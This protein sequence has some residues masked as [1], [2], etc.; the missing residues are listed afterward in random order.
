[1]RI[2]L[3][4]AGTRRLTARTRRHEECALLACPEN[5]GR[6]T[7]GRALRHGLK[8]I[9]VVLRARSQRHTCRFASRAHLRRR[10]TL[11]G[12]HRR[13][14]KPMARPTVQRLHR[15]L[16]LEPEQQRPSDL[17]TK[18]TSFPTLSVR[19]RL[20]S[21]RRSVR[22]PR[23]LASHAIFLTRVRRDCQVKRLAQRTAAT[24]PQSMRCGLPKQTRAASGGGSLSLHGAAR[25][26]QICKCRSTLR[27]GAPSSSANVYLC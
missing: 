27:K 9:E 18:P 8:S 12:C 20:P 13:S 10:S 6:C 25:G 16:R 23:N 5:H 26:H 1:M 17:K 11:S 19:A 21:L 15:S 14:A 24:Q 7:H 3:L 4:D 2:H 22:T